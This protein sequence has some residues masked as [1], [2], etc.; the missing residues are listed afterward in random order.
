MIV[1]TPKV[2]NGS[3]DEKSLNLLDLE[4]AASF[5]KDNL[6]VKELSSKEYDDTFG[7]VL[8]KKDE[9]VPLSLFSILSILFK[10]TISIRKV[11]GSNFVKN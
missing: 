10:R 5:S 9:Q 6:F 8:R 11:I 2:L 3:T 4:N 1:I 7:N